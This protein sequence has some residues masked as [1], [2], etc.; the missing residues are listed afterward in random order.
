[1]KSEKNIEQYLVKKVKSE[2]GK[3]YKWVSPGN[4]GVPD[5]IVFM[6][7][8][9]VFMFE[10]KAPGKKPTP[11]QLAKHRELLKFGQTVFVVDNTE[12]IDKLFREVMPSEV[13]TT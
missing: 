7:G 6:P 3:A 12:M 9:R 1:M 13:H 11:L 4:D 10:L 2:G 8:G 5:R